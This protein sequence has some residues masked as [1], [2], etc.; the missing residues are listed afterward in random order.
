MDLAERSLRI[1]V[2]SPSDVA[3]ERARDIARKPQAD[4]KL[5]ED[6][7]F[8]IEAIEEGLASLPN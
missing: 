2:S 6:Q 8:W 4:G 7:K 3:A 1:F 5:P